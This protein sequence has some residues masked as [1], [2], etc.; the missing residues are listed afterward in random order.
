MKD[1]VAEAVA[2]VS[3]PEPDTPYLGPTGEAPAASQPT[4]SKLT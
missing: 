4:R 3:A 2:P 1:A